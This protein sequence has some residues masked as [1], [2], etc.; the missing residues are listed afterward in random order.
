MRIAITGASGLLGRALITA[1]S[2]HHR[3][4]A[5][6]H[7]APVI[8]DPSIETVPLDLSDPDSISRF[9]E[10]ASANVIIHTAAIADVDCCEREP[11][12][13]RSLNAAAT[14]LIVDNLR[15]S[16]SRLVYIS[17]DY[18]FDGTGG[19]YNE[20][21]RPHP[22][23]VYG[24]TKL[25]GETAVL[26]LEEQAATV[27]SASFLGHG[28]A[29]HP[30]FAEHM[31]E[32]MRERPPLRAPHDQFSNVTPVDGLA[33]GIIE[34]VESCRAGIWHIA[35]PQILS[36]YD[37]AMMMAELAGI[38][39]ACVEPVS[40]ESLHRPAARPLRGGL[41]TDKATEALAI[42]WRPLRES[43][44]AFLRQTRSH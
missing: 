13:A 39:P 9:V 3:I 36:R 16:S 34:I 24:Q 7:T 38:D 4:I 31:L 28:D 2:P 35:H 21:D 17:T 41:K 15:G 12:L 30:T 33:A 11:E 44:S 18:V 27:R 20:S 26:A 40:Y 23:N 10:A 6:T 42:W 8:S 37:L 29:R 14:R 32:T 1:A 5:A 19:P 43:V 22:I 25:D